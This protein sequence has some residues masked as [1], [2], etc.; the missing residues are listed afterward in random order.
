MYIWGVHKN[1]GPEDLRRK[2]RVVVWDCKRDEC[3]SCGDEK[4]N[5]WQVFA[6]PSLTVKHREGFD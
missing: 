1:M 4:G 3:N 5:N 6:G 2:G